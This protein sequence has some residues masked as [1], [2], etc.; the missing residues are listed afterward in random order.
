[1]EGL[2]LLVA[3]LVGDF[4]FQ[5]DAQAKD[6]SSPDPGPKPMHLPKPDSPF[7][8]Y[9]QAA[10]EKWEVAN[11]RWLTGHVV[12]TVHCLLYTV[13]FF[14]CCGWFLSWWAYP[15]L[16][17][18][19]W[20]IDRFRLARKL[21]TL[22]GQ[23]E[24]ATGPLSPWSVVVVDQCLHLVVATIVGLLAVKGVPPWPHPMSG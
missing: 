3:H 7:E 24:F 22:T 21:M 15:V 20:P 17:V 10:L 14:L 16:F 6:K 12:C 9:D 18:T 5:N 19:H 2:C 11:S 13:A 23:E 8:K 4:L 1:M